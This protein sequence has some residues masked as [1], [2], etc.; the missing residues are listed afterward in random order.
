ML[1]SN[2]SIMRT[3]TQ[4]P[5]KRIFSSCNYSQF[6]EVGYPKLRGPPHTHTTSKVQYRERGVCV[7]ANHAFQGLWCPKR[8]FVGI[9]I[10]IGPKSGHTGMPPSLSKTRRQYREGG[11]WQGKPCLSRAF[12]VQNGYL[13]EY[14]QRLGRNRGP[15]TRRNTIH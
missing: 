8:V 5:G 13:G 4:R 3:S 10:A 11:G 9:P 6:V 12:G 7:R 15:N 2:T 14:S 1:H